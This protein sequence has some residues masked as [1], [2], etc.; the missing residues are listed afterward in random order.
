[1]ANVA[2]ITGGASGMG[3]AVAK[4]LSARTN[5][6]IHIFDINEEHGARTAQDLPRTTFHRA[7]VTKYSDLAAAFQSTFQQHNKLDFVFANAGVIER[8]NFYSTPETGTGK[9]VCPPPEPDLP[10]IDVDLKGVVFTTYLAQHYF[11]HSSHK[12]QGSS[13]VMTASCGG[14]YPSFYSPLYSAAKFGVVGFMR[15]ISQHF[16]AAGIRVNAICPGIV[17]TNL[18]DSNGWDSFPPGRF[19][20]VDTVARVVLH[21]VD[22]G[23]PAGQGLTDTPGRHLPLAELYGIAVEISDSGLYF[24]DQHEFCDEGMREVMAATVV[25]NQVGAILNGD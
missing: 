20:E 4:A 2:I 18:V 14:L 7:D 3:L 19:I 10:A 5:W 17:R 12:G 23:D 13:L 6:E 8:T 11:R 16:R 1:M 15:S 25:E 22:G 9:D 24:R 21:L